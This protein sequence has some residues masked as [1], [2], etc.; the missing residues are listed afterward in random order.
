MV[1]VFA[2]GVNKTILE[3]R[4]AKKGHIRRRSQHAEGTATKDGTRYIRSLIEQLLALSGVNIHSCAV[5]RAC[6]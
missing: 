2:H 5:P 6:N 1:E 3:Q 4:V